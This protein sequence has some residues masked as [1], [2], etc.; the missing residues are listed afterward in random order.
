MP[1]DKGNR[2]AVS[3]DWLWVIGTTFPSGTALFVILSILFSEKVEGIVSETVGE[4]LE[5]R[6]FRILCLFVGLKQVSKGMHI[7]INLS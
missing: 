5:I 1:P 4:I 3:L 7:N 2:V 6:F